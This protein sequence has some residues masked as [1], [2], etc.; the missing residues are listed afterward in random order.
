MPITAR[1]VKS[2]ETHFTKHYLEEK[3]SPDVD[4]TEVGQRNSYKK[5][6]LGQRHVQGEHCVNTKRAVY[7]PKREAWLDPSLTA[8][9]N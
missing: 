8:L 1:A 5:R 6:K 4:S 7:K 9:R 3:A 2:E